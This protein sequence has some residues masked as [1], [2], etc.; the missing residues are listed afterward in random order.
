M[1]TTIAKE[2]VDFLKA[3]KKN[4]NREWFNKNKDKYVAANENFLAFTA[5]LINAVSKFDK[6]VT[7]IE[8]KDCVFRIYRD[9]RFAKDKTPY[10]NNFGMHIMPQA[11]SC[12]VAG[13]YFYFE[14]G[15]SFLGGGVHTTEPANLKA[16]RQEISYNGKDFLKIINDK[17]FK[18]TFELRGEKL[19]KVPQ[20][21]DKE[22][23]MAEYLKYK[24]LV[25]HHAVPDG[26]ITLP[27]FADYCAKVFK[28]MVPFNSFLN[29]PVMK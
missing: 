15:A 11:K 24:E 26:E 7:G 9:T 16:I 4:N 12:G 1:K 14:P 8:A 23:P 29:E 21:F 10:K 27:G 19:V 17:N 3:L 20:G 28:A 5:E 2:T 13:Y 22:D 18:Q 25:I 6:A